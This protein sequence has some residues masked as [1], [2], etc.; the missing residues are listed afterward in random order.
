MVPGLRLSWNERWGSTLTPRLA[1]RYRVTD[2]LS[3]RAG[4]GRGFRAPDFKELYLQFI[5]DAAGY[6]VYGNHD[7]RPEHST[8]VSGGLEWTGGRLYARSQ[9][10]WN[11]LHDFIETRPMA[12][13]GSGLLLF[14]YANV[15][16][17]RTYGA[18]LEAG[19]ALPGLRLEA[20]YAWLGTEDVATDQPL[21]GRPTHSG[22][23]VTTVAPAPGLN[24]TVSGIYT[25]ATPMERDETGSITS[26]RE[27]FLRIDARVARR[28]PW[29][30]E[31]S[32]G[33]DNIFDRRPDAWADAVGREWYVGLTWLTTSLSSN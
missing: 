14:Q 18:E 20:G 1:V 29:G 12:D 5:N 24:A 23:L 32:L 31:L 11:D 30:L 33:A 25:G 9:L 15:A 26:E 3:V 22:R 16:R 7:L 10:F 27:A 21:L 19:L 8:N 13:D 2:A 6:A 17:A 28:L 4:A